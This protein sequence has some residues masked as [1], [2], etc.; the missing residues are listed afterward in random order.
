MALVLQRTPRITIHPLARVL[1]CGGAGF[2]GFGLFRVTLG[3][4]YAEALV[5]ATFWEE[6]TELM[7]VSAAIYILWVFR[8]TLL[9]DFTL[10]Q[11]FKKAFQ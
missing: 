1:L 11:A 10:P 6:V 9:P 3:L 2:L 5:W 7:F 8:S 4:V